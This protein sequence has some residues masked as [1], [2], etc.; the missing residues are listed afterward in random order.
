MNR[1][2]NNEVQECKTGHM[3]VR[4]L[5]GVRKQMIVKKV[6]MVDVLSIQVLIWSIQIC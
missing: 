6:N 3:K 5:R 2:L 4:A 1:H